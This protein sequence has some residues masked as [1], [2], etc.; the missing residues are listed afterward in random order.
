M[1]K[2][3]HPA[4]ERGYNDIGWLKANFSFSFAGYYDPAKVHFG[5]LRVLNDDYIAPAMGFG[6]HPHD[7]MEI[8]TVVSKGALEHKD[9]MGNVGI[10]KAGEVQIMSAGTGI[11]HSEYNPS[12]TEETNSF[13]IWIFPKE[14]NIKPR[15]DQKSFTGAM[16]Q[17]ELTTLID[18]EKSENTL[19]INQ[20]SRLSMGNFDAGKQIDYKMQYPN[21]G[22]YVF[23]I[24]GSVEV[25]GTTLNKRDATGISDTETF[26]IHTT[27]AATILIIEVP[28]F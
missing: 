10:I 4:N 2:V 17:N 25:E 19:W 5:A 26:S 27:T 3:L 23:V 11:M 24:D 9:S 16:V 22:A 7:N 13:Q 28:M 15:Y 21:S 6:M 1:K 14:N 8:I 18:G 12:K 20:D